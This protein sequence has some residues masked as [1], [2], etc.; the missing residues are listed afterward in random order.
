[1][2]M[3]YIEFSMLNLFNTD[4]RKPKLLCTEERHLHETFG[5]HI[6][7]SCVIF[8]N[9]TEYTL[10]FRSIHVLVTTLTLMTL[11]TSSAA[12]WPPHHSIGRWSLRLDKDHNGHGHKDNTTRFWMCSC[13]R[14]KP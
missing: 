8:C 14:H 10:K 1:M 12:H 7:N 9:V 6:H 11:G 3:V 5:H 4:N 13:A 2:F